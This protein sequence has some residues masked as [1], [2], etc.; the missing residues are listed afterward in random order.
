MKP[1]I[2]GTGNY[3]FGFTPRAE[4]TRCT[5]E[6]LASVVARLTAL[7]NDAATDL[8]ATETKEGFNAADAHAEGHGPGFD[9]G[10]HAGKRAGLDAAILLLSQLKP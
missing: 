7:R 3:R 4:E 5:Y 2:P 1:R 8:D 10:F 6:V 9:V